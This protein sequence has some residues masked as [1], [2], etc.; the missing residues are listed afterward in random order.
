V[1]SESEGP[2]RETYFVLSVPNVPRDGEASHL[3]VGSYNISQ[4]TFPKLNVRGCWD[5]DTY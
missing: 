4:L 3:H 1:S 5:N 2:I